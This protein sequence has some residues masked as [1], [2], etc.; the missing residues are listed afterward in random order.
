MNFLA[1]PPPQY[2]IISEVTRTSYDSSL[3][4]FLIFISMIAPIKALLTFTAI[5]MI[6][7]MMIE[8][9]MMM[10]MMISYL[11]LELVNFLF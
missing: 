10:M 3:S 2:R 7:M 9:M 8:M 11:Q 6:E 5:T 4:A 1:S